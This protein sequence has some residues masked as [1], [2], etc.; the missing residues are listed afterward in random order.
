MAECRS[1]GAPIVWA[2]TH[3]GKSIPIDVDPAIG[4]PANYPDGNIALF[5][6]VAEVTASGPHKSHFATCKDA[7]SWRKKK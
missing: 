2:R 3:A 5:N 1:C 6:G 7:A 4:G